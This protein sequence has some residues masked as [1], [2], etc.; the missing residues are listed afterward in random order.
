MPSGESAELSAASQC[1]KLG[2]LW[3]LVERYPELRE[4]IRHFNPQFVSVAVNTCTIPVN[5]HGEPRDDCV[6]FGLFY[7]DR[8]LVNVPDSRKAIRQDYF[9]AWLSKSEVAYYSGERSIWKKGGPPKHWHHI[10]EFCGDFAGPGD[11]YGCKLRE[12]S[13]IEPDH[14]YRVDDE[15]IRRMNPESVWRSAFDLAVAIARAL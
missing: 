6:V 15:N 8:K 5:A 9:V 4:I 14:Y 1:A 7:V 2:Q 11:G 12:D 3:E 10:R 13:L